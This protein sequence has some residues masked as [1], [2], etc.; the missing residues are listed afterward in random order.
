M[1]GAPTQRATPTGDCVLKFP[2]TLLAYE[3]AFGD[4]RRVLDERGVHAKH[5]YNVELV[6]EEIVTNVIRHGGSPD[7]LCSIEVTLGFDEHSV[8]MGF[9]DNGPAFDPTNHAM[10]E[11]SG[12]VEAARIGGLG[13][14]L[15]RNACARMEYERTRQNTNRLIVTIATG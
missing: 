2:A 9:Y 6:Y 12:S 3:R 5:R 7:G 1:S 4:L 11:L 10:P 13:L 8:I 15:I 14:K